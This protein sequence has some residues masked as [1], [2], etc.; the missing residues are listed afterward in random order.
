MKTINPHILTSILKFIKNRPLFDFDADG[1]T[2]HRLLLEKSAKMFKPVRSVNFTPVDINTVSA[3]WLSP[4]QPTGNRILLYI[5]GGGF[6]AG[7]INTHRDLASRIANTSGARVLIM[8][9]RLAPEHKFPAGLEDIFNSYQWLLDQNILPES[10]G[11]AGDSAGGGLALSL[12]LMIKSH[13]LPMPSATALLSPW[14]DLSCSGHSLESNQDVDPM[15]NLSL[16]QSAANIYAS[17]QAL[18]DPLVSPLKG[19]FSGLCPMLIQIGTLEILQ[20]DAIKLAK[21]AKESGVDVTLETWEGMFHVWHYFS[22]YLKQGKEA[23][24][25]IGTFFRTHLKG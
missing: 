5:H 10:I 23:V 11:I 7:S 13:D 14:V 3:A 9:Y 17:S 19:D 24:N 22:K 16:L 8:N 12:L 2:R 1:V 6:N 15:L 20:D 18:N 4:E 21:K 25:N